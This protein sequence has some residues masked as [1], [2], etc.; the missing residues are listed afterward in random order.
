M[1][2]E[3]DRTRIRSL[4]EA[5]EEESWRFR[6]YLKGLELSDAALDCLV[7]RHVDDIAAPIDC[8]ACANCCTYISPQLSHRDI[9]RLA[10][11]LGIDKVRLI[12][13]YLRRPY[14]GSRY[15]W[16][17]LPC[18]FLQNGR[19]IVYEARP[20]D[21]RSF[22]H[23]RKREFRSRL[24]RV[25]GNCSVCPIVYHVFERLKMELRKDAAEKREVR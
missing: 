23:L 2:I 19:C 14:E 16:E 18:S 6:A 9:Q 5:K 3:I 25:V 17:R 4:A 7:S 24:I 13:E 1:D 10:D 20:D 22:P 12:R 15:L 8:C 11:H 21:C